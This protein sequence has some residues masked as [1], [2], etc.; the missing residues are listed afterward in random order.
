MSV[1]G[2]EPNS[3]APA[4]R[5]VECYLI[6]RAIIPVG[7][8]PSTSNTCFSL[9]RSA[10]SVAGDEPNSRAPAERHVE[11]YLIERAIIPCRNNSFNK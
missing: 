11:C 5:H 6:E 4:E 2:D 1:T 8:I 9:Q 7:I 3:R 10:M